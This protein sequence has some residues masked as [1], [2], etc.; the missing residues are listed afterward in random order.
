MVVWLIMNVVSM[1]T[2]LG[3]LPSDCFGANAEPLCRMDLFV[4]VMKNVSIS[5]LEAGAPAVLR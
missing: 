5:A 3:L 4:F 1:N 2:V